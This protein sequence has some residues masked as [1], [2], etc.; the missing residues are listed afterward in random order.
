MQIKDALQDGALKLKDSVATH[1]VA[2]SHQ[3]GMWFSQRNMNMDFFP[4][5]SHYHDTQKLGGYVDI[6]SQCK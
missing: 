1:T 4:S 5:L 3:M 6:G 2:T